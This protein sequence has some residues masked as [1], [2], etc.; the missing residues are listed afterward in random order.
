MVPET[1]REA[2]PRTAEKKVSTKLRRISLR[3]LALVL[4][5]FEII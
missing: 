1:F 2:R 5:L 3:Y 4:S